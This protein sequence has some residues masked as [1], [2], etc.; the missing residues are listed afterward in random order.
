MQRGD[1]TDQHEEA[2]DE[3]DEPALPEL[4]GRTRESKARGLTV[5]ADSTGRG[6]R[7]DR[8]LAGS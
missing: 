5:T 3:Q 2:D 6:A 8:A 4:F 1:H 7:R